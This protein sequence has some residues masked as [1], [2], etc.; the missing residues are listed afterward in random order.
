MGGFLYSKY[1]RAFLEKKLEEFEQR[2]GKIK[3]TMTCP[4]RSIMETISAQKV[5]YGII[6]E[7]LSIGVSNNT[8]T[9][10]E[11]GKKNE[12]QL[13]QLW[14]KNNVVLE[15]YSV[16]FGKNIK[17]YFMFHEYSDTPI[18][19]NANKFGIRIMSDTFSDIPKIVGNYVLSHALIRAEGEE[20]GHVITGFI[21]DN[22]KYYIYDNGEHYELD[23]TKKENIPKLVGHFEDYFEKVDNLRITAV[24]INKLHVTTNNVNRTM[25]MKTRLL[26][27]PESFL[28]NYLR[29]E[30][31]RLNRYGPIFEKQK[32][33]LLRNRFGAN[34]PNIK[35]IEKSIFESA[36]KLKRNRPIINKL[37]IE[38][39][40]KKALL[41]LAQRAYAKEI[42]NR[43]HKN[44]DRNKQ[45]LEKKKIQTA[46]EKRLALIKYM[47]ENPEFVNPNVGR[48]GITRITR[49]RKMPARPQ[50][51]RNK[52]KGGIYNKFPQFPNS[53]ENIKKQL[54]NLS[55]KKNF[56][57]ENELH[58]V[59]LTKKYLELKK[60]KIINHRRNA[61]PGINKVSEIKPENLPI[62]RREPVPAQTRKNRIRLGGRKKFFNAEK[63]K[64]NG[65]KNFVFVSKSSKLPHPF[66]S[67]KLKNAISKY[68]NKSQ[69]MYQPEHFIRV[70]LERRRMQMV[71]KKLPNASSLNSVNHKNLIIKALS[72]L[73][74]YNPKEK[75][76]FFSQPF[77]KTFSNYNGT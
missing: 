9:L 60:P 73:K 25:N 58:R 12:G 30:Y 15:L 19:I 46:E 18:I 38:A 63:L 5:Y 53:M 21:C 55:L 4:M 23:W 67:E 45:A 75:M 50:F 42:R 59:K 66:F 1:G 62:T 54:N 6:K 11:F 44:L 27:S 76:S 36:N 26:N 77:L 48:G 72:A 22:D 2:E 69:G 57:P 71:N 64:G 49:N 28:P 68:K 74:G 29:Q 35:K 43:L 39:Q 32:M 10:R 51:I 7:F 61:K 37:K 70:L 65:P 40:Q 56:G 20:G 31:N 52:L 17:K 33:N 16:L 8:N 47:D 34:R 3:S 13:T 24:W 41:I 14:I